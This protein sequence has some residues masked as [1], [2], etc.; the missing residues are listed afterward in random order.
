MNDY[1]KITIG[2][3]PDILFEVKNYDD[4]VQLVSM[5]VDY[6]KQVQKH[7][8]EEIKGFA[9]DGIVPLPVTMTKIERGGDANE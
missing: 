2:N 7:Y 1:Y 3:D 4:A 5:L 8:E 6:G 9:V